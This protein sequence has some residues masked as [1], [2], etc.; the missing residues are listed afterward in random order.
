MS[1]CNKKILTIVIPAYNVAHYL[2]KTLDSL[3]G[4]R[5]L[6]ALDIIIVNDG[7]TDRT[8]EIAGRYAASCPESVRLVSKENGGHGSGINT[9]L[10][11]AAGSYF[12]VL[13]GDDWCSSEALDRILAIMVSAEE[14]V[15]AANFQ[16]Y[17]M[18]SGETVHYRFGKIAYD[19]RYSM[20]E[21]VR[22]GVPL[23]MHELFYRTDLLRRIRL[24]IR[25]K[26]SYDDEEYCIMPFAAAASVRFID[27][28]YYVYRQGDANQSMSPANQLRRYR[29]KYEVLKDMLRYADRPGIAP[30]NLAYMQGRIENLITSVYFLWLIGCP[31]RKKG[32]CEAARFRAWLKAEEPLYYRRTARL[33]IAFRLF[34][35]LRFDT[36]RWDAFRDF[37]K[38]LLAAVGAAGTNEI[39]EK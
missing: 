39:K 14:D 3:V 11:L 18:D 4:C 9:G 21:L 20:D 13:D 15:L 12:S 36:R 31:D 8:E 37:R 30:A 34:H 17:R 25:E 27:E 28:E 32:R 6:A 24:H 26:V 29:D 5:Q 35:L 7:S 33:W 2:E 19:R 38:K 16:T 1:N 23:V 22:S 10:K